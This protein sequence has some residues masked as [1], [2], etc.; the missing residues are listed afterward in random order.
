MDLLIQQGLCLIF[1]II[2]D[3]PEGGL[4]VEDLAFKA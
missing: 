2:N 1:V 3:W 4:E